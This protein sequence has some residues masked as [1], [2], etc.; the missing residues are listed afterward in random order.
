MRLAL[1]PLLLSRRCVLLY[2]F[3]GYDCGYD[4]HKDAERETATQVELAE[5]FVDSPSDALQTLL[6]DPPLL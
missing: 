4:E 5:V 2:L 1:I 3:C 6:N